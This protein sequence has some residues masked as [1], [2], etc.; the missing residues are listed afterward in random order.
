[1]SSAIEIRLDEHPV[2]ATKIRIGCS[3]SSMHLSA[4]LY[5]YYLYSC[6]TFLFS[7]CSIAHTLTGKVEDA[8]NNTVALHA[9]CNGDVKDANGD[10]ISC[11]LQSL[12]LGETG[13]SYPRHCGGCS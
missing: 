3:G 7:L 12:A 6:K 2:D 11:Q 1:M 8:H 9:V 4:H 5:C 10:Q 13:M